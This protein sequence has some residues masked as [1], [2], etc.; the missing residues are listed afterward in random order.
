MPEIRA[1]LIVETRSNRVRAVW[2]LFFLWLLCFSCFFIYSCL[3]HIFNL[4]LWSLTWLPRV[5][6]FFF[7]KPDDF[8]IIPNSEIWY[9]YIECVFSKPIIKSKERLKLF[10]QKNVWKF[11]LAKTSKIFYT[12]FTYFWGIQFFICYQ[13]IENK[14]QVL[15]LLKIF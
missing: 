1:K 13:N 5:A 6:A 8:S 11:F 7:M 14:F 3:L 10:N 12:V 15:F 2:L 4:L 9:A